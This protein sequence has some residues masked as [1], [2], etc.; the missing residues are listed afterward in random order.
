MATITV[1]NDLPR[2]LRGEE[3]ACQCTRRRFD[4]EV[5]ETPL[6]GGMAT[7]SG[8]L[9]R[10]IPWTEQTGRLQSMQ[11]LRVTHD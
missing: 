8:I 5:W 10:K 4:S 1:A 3:S 2:W 11:L 7:H 9:T 6:G